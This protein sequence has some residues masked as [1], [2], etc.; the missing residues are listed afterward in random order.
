MSDDLRLRPLSEGLGLGSLRNTKARR[1][2]PLDIN[3]QVMRQPAFDAYVPHSVGKRKKEATGTR[4]AVWIVR[5]SVGWMLDCVVLLSSLLVCST[6]GIMAWRIG[7]GESDGASAVVA[8]DVMRDA[9]EKYGYVGL[10]IV[11]GIASI[12]YWGVLSA[13]AGG[14]PGSSMRSPRIG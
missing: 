6:L 14:T 3:P 1:V 4:F 9:M 10:A 12:V 13:L 11:I 5:A 8:F 2:E 7:V